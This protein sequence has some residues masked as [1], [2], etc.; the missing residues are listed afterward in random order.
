MRTPSPGEGA[1]PA[2]SF[3]LFV[4][5]LSGQPGWFA[6]L[7]GPTSCPLLRL[8]LPLAWNA[9]FPFSTPLNPVYPEGPAPNLLLREDFFPWPHLE[10]L[11]PPLSMGSLQPT[12]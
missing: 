2:A 3:P 8:C 11:S 6:H 10:E 4:P 12:P 9:L 5:A 1:T 7:S